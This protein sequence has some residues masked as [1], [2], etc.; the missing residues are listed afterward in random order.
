M[1]LAE[2]RHL[3]ESLPPG[4]A[5]TLPREALLALCESNAPTPALESSGDFTVEQLAEILGRR[6]S[7]VRG[8]LESGLF[9][10][11]YH[12][13][14]SG[15]LSKHGRP[16]VG[17]WRIPAAGVEAFRAAGKKSRRVR[18]TDWRAVERAG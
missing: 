11:A 7:T 18:L 15:K 4:S 10:G 8:W 12:L 14:A 16:K 2:L 6:P 17:A 3:A 1:T 13:P 9:P 5:L